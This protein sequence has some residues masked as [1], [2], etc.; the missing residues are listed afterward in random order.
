MTNNRLCSGVTV[1]F[2]LILVLCNWSTWP[3]GVTD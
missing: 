3:S 2:I 1:L